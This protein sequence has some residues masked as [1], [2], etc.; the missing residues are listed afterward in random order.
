[1]KKQTILCSAKG[2]SLAIISAITFIG[3]VISISA[4]DQ[5]TYK[6]GDA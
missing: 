4:Q 5:P 3:A 1:M 2:L 6:I